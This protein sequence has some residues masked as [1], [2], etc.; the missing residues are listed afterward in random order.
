MHDID[1]LQPEFESEFE[2]GF[3]DEFEFESDDQ[4]IDTGEA[5]EDTPVLGDDEEMELAADLL[6]ATS[7]QELDQFLGK[8][9]RKV[10]R[11]VRKVVRSPIGKALGGVL[12]KVAKKALPMAGAALGNV[13][14]PGV[15][16]AI[17]GK[18]GSMAGGIFG[19]ELE[20][21]SPE[22]QEFEVARRFVRLAA[23]S[24]ANAARAPQGATASQV[25]RNAVA[26]AARRHA[27]GLVSGGMRTRG[28]GAGRWVRRGNSIILFGA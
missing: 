13:F 14:M 16:G 20:S 17:G 4:F 11:S 10:S 6:N 25:A 8:L 27:P 19:L 18:L 5:F 15:G 22:D 7:D 26:A 9:I 1:T 2:S 12:R 21:L 24:T 3:D 28:R 23:Q